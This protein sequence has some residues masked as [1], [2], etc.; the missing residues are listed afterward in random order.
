MY[1]VSLEGRRY[2]QT[3]VYVCFYIIFIFILYHIVLTF[4]IYFM[5]LLVFWFS[6]VGC[7]GVFTNALYCVKLCAMYFW[8]CFYY[9]YYISSFLRSVINMNLNVQLLKGTEG[10]TV[11]YGINLEVQLPCRGDWRSGTDVPSSFLFIT[12]WL[13]RTKG[14]IYKEILQVKKGL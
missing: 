9:V 2:G 3:N 4:I 10:V 8:N 12:S 13:I 6:S 1:V 7:L 14:D 5:M 11:M